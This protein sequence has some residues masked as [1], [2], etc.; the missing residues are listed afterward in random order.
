MKIFPAI[1]LMKNQCVRLRQGRADAATVYNDDPVDQALRWEAQGGEYLHLVDLDGAFAGEPR[2][3]AVIGRIVAAVKI[4]VEVGGGLRT[5]DH[6]REL[7]NVGVDRVILGTRALAEPD[8]LRRLVATFGARVAVG[9]DARGGFVQVKG[10]VETTTTRAADLARDVA[11]M[12][13][14]TII[15]TDT[16][17]DGML[18][19][20]NLAG[21]AA[22]CDAVPAANVVASG[23]V[24]KVEDVR[25]LAALKRTNLEG[26]IVGKAL[27]EGTATLAELLA[28]VR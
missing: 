13:V 28:A 26:A 20:P 10:W 2:H 23:G 9:I 5:D 7:L 6:V 25:D 11:A 21:M 1:D 12:G 14:Q 16:A 19:G 3:T 17:T 8:A 18:K 4:P 22:M 15:Y 27:Y 24:S